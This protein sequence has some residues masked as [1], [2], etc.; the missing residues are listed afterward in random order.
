MNT[1]KDINVKTIRFSPETDGKLGKLAERFRRSKLLLFS[2]MV[3]Y[4]HRTKKDPLDV[5]DEALRN[6]L[7]KN[8]DTYIRFI[9]AQEE[10]IL[11]PV[12][13]EVERMIK[14]QK[15]I[16]DRF[17]DQVLNFNNQQLA[18]NEKLMERQQAQMT[19]QKLQ[20]QRFK[21]SDKILQSL[22]DR[23]DTKELL[24]RKF[25]AIFNQYLKNRDNITSLFPGKEKGELAED[26]RQQ[27]SKI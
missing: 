16:L 11:I 23:M 13:S 24:K 9:R 14:S 6:T 17:N 18:A 21:E 7:V 5:N 3:D 4:F 20:E 10:K 26:V 12:Q 27:I 19:S 25:L 15:K 8:H 2:Q 1:I 22:Y